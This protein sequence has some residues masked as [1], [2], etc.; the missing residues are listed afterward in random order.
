[1][2]LN[3]PVKIYDA[4]FHA[5]THEE[6]ER[7]FYECRIGDV[8][9]PRVEPKEAL[10]GVVDDFLHAIMDKRAPIS[11]GYFGCDVIR[12]LEA[13]QKSIKNHGEPIPVSNTESAESLLVGETL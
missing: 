10:A 6:K 2:D 5:K 7:L 8:Y 4:T 13:A 12:V 9:S 11:N 1:M 3:E